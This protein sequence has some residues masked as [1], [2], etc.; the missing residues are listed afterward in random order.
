MDEERKVKHVLRSTDE[1]Y[2]YVNLYKIH[3][4]K[5]S[6]N[7]ALEDLIILGWNKYKELSEKDGKKSIL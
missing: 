7:D 5:S 4:S 1:I 6:V 3:A 2:K